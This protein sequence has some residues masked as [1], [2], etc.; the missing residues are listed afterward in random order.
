[1]NRIQRKTDDLSLTWTIPAG[2]QLSNS[3]P[4]GASGFVGGLFGLPASFTGSSVSFEWSKDNVT[5]FPLHQEYSDTLKSL[6]VTAAK[7]YPLPDEVF[8][9]LYLKIHSSSSEASDRSIVVCPI[10]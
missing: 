9:A 3:I 6:T 8:G 10:S 1:M 2:Q 4:L 7:G 5:F